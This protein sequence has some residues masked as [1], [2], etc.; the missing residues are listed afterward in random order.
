MFLFV[1]DLFITGLSKT[2]MFFRYF[3]ILC[4]KKTILALCCCGKRAF[5]EFYYNKKK[6]PLEIYFFG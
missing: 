3:E 5:C 4:T 2:K 1:Y 6:T